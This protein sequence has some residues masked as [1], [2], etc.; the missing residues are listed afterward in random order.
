MV[1]NAGGWLVEK[2]NWYVHAE[3]GGAHQSLF[4]AARQRQRVPVRQLVQAEL[5]QKFWARLLRNTFGKQLAVYILHDQERPARL[6]RK[7]NRA[8]LHTLQTAQHPGQGGF[9]STIGANNA[10]DLAF[11]ETH[12][13]NVEHAPATKRHL[14]PTHMHSPLRRRRLGDLI[15][16]RFFERAQP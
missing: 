4:L 11:W 14:H 7:L 8:G 2:Q 12:I 6:R 9:T 15:Q 16:L 10:G 3:G 13:G 1:V 5:R